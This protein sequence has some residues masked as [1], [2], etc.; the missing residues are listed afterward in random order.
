MGSGLYNPKGVLTLASE[1]KCVEAESKT[2][3]SL[4]MDGPS[5]G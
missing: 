4:W 1:E 2:A 3:N 5:L